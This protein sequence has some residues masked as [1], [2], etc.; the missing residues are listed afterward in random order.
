MCSIIPHI[1]FQTRVQVR[2]GKRIGWD[3]VVVKMKGM[4]IFLKCEDIDY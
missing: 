4:K 3:I 2:V 1:K